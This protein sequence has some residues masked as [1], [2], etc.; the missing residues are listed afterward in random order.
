MPA[1]LAPLEVL[2]AFGAFD[3]FGFVVAKKAFAATCS[4]MRMGHVR[5]SAPYPVILLV[6]VALESSNH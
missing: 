6:V 1:A 5:P 2:D 4:K 3:F